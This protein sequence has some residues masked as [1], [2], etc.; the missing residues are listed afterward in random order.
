MRRHG[1]QVAGAGDAEKRRERGPQIKK[2]KRSRP[3]KNQCRPF[4]LPVRAWPLMAHRRAVGDVRVGMGSGGIEIR[5]EPPVATSQP[6]G[7]PV[8]EDMACLFGITGKTS[9]AGGSWEASRFQGMRVLSCQAIVFRHS[10][11]FFLCRFLSFCELV[12]PP[13][14]GLS[15]LKGNTGCLPIICLSIEKC[16]NEGEHS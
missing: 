6:A 1:V 13:A 4:D 11:R 9:S 16:K 3:A 14:N 12:R 7:R 10:V 2:R 15:K 5:D 8:Q